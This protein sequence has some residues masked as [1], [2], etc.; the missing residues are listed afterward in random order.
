MPLEGSVGKARDFSEELAQRLEVRRDGKEGAI[1]VTGYPKSGKSSALREAAGRLKREMLLLRAEV[2]QIAE[3]KEVQLVL[4]D[5]RGAEAVLDDPDRGLNYIRERMKEGV[6]VAVELPKSLYFP[7]ATEKRVKEL[8]ELLR[9]LVDGLRR[10]SAVAPFAIEGN[11][12]TFDFIEERGEG[13]SAKDPDGILGRITKPLKSRIGHERVVLRPPAGSVEVAYGKAEAKALLEKLAKNLDEKKKEL[14]LRSARI[15]HGL[16]KGYYFPGLLVKGI[17]NPEALDKKVI[18]EHEGFENQLEVDAVGVG[19]ADAV[20]GR[21]SSAIAQYLREVFGSVLWIFS[22]LLA[23]GLGLGASV[24]VFFLFGLARKSEDPVKQALEK[25]MKWEKL[26]EERKEYLSY[27][28]DV[29]LALP[30]GTARRLLNDFF[31]QSEDNTWQ[32]IEELRRN[33]ERL[34]KSNDKEV[35]ALAWLVAPYLIEAG[36]IS[37]E[38]VAAYKEG[39]LDLLESNDE[40]KKW[41][42]WSIIPDLIEAGV[43]SKEDAAAHKEG[44]LELLESN[45]V[46]IKPFAAMYRPTLPTWRILDYLIRAGVITKEDQTSSPP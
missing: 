25:R 23:L 19:L 33:F 10:M 8:R 22:S 7:G 12:Y 30:P 39:F 42:A 5:D 44:F 15:N 20:Y 35:K 32:M 38:E 36:V 3:G 14:V 16:H 40:D 4:K 29:A 46:E 45:P 26:P 37:K 21:A 27:R 9:L 13:P 43:I 34:L 11:N 2:V 31:H 24:I 17:E 41:F 1:L 6:V 18:K 28:Y